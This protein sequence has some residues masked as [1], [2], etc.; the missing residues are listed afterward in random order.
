[1]DLEVPE[2]PFSNKGINPF[3]VIARSYG[4]YGVVVSEFL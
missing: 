2:I 3:L 4:S 1:M